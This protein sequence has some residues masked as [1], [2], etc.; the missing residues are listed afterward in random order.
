MITSGW[1]ARAWL[2]HSLQPCGVPFPSQSVT[3]TPAAVRPSLIESVMILLKGIDVL[4]SITQADFPLA[5]LALN[6][7]PGC[8][9]AQETGPRYLFTSAF[10]AATPSS[11]AL[12]T[13]VLE[14]VALLPRLVPPT[15]SATI[16]PQATSNVK[17]R[18]QRF[19]C[20]T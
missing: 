7:G 4:R 13:L 16:A 3:L 18:W 2:E 1:F 8:E 19:Q 20:G 17:R 5:A 12:L 15:A 9:P 11:V 6:A 14:R 10:A